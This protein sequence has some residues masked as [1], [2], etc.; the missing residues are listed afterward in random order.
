M[1]TSGIEVWAPDG[2]GEVRAGDDLAALVL[3]LVEL[4]DGDVLVVTSKVVSKAEG[5]VVSGTTREEALAGETVRVVARRGPTT[6]V[7]TRHGLTMAAAGIDASNVEVGS[8]VLLPLDP[9][10]SARRLR[11]AVRERTGRNVG[12]VV[13]DT[14]GRA[15][16]EGQTDIAVGAAGLLVAEDFGGRVDA[17]GNPL[18]VTAPAVAD[19]IAGVAEL[20][21]GKLGARPFA[22][23]RGRADLVLAPGDDGP[24]ARAL[25][26]P[27]GGDLFGYGAREA[28][29]R[30]VLGD[31][32]DQAP[33]GS[34]VPAEELAAVLRLLPGVEV[35]A[36]EDGVSVTGGPAEAVAALAFAHGWR[37]DGAGSAV[38]ARLRPATT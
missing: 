19:E 18:V 10:D 32:A 23:V 21:S 30:A 38:E 12:V 7:R 25:V 8:V 28:V 11:A 29:V 3:P 24:G 17:H 34:P 20:A 22:V 5:R 31:P 35:A 37:V 26:R 27:E 15:W 6:I 16:R 1:T 13:T 14:A 36:T 2:V 9:D 4:A 33:F